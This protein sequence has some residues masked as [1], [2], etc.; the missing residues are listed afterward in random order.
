[1]MTPLHWSSYNND[2][3]TIT[4]LLE[5][6]ATM[7]ENKQGYTPI[8]LAGVMD[9]N[10]TVDAFLDFF[11]ATSKEKGGEDDGIGDYATVN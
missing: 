3:E 6:G 1:M 2:P 5:N 10:E 7:K 4:Y 9:L 8:D 11:F